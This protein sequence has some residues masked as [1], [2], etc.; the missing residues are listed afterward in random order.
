[1]LSSANRPQ[2]RSELNGRYERLYI[3]RDEY[4]DAV[5]AAIVRGTPPK[6]DAQVQATGLTLA[7]AQRAAITDLQQRRARAALAGGVYDGHKKVPKDSPAF[8]S[9]ILQEQA[10]AADAAEALAEATARVGS[11]AALH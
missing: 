1:M 10:R 3:L 4:E 5:A 7:T 2:I 9:L 6:E 11:S 8:L